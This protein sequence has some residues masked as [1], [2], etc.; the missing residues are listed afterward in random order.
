MSAPASAPPESSAADPPAA[1]PSTAGLRVVRRDGTVSGFD[2]SKIAVAMTKAFLAVEGGDAGASSR[3]HHLVT[4]LTAQVRDALARFPAAAVHVEQIQDQ[5][6]LALMRGEHH[7]AARSYVLYREERAKARDAAGPAAEHSTLHVT[8]PDGTRH[9]LDWDRLESVVGE[10]VAGIDAV[11]AEPVLAE[12]RRNLYDGITADEL[13]QAPVMAARTLVEL[14]P[15]Y[16]FVAAR[17]L[18]GRLRGEALSYLAG[19]PRRLDQAGMAE[20]YPDYVRDYLRRAIELGLADPELTR[21]DLDRLTAAIRPERDLDFGF[22]GL[23]TLYDRYFLHH[24]GTRFELP[25]AFFLR[26]AMGLAVRERDREARAI[27][28]YELL[29]RLDFM[30]STPTLFNA[31]TTRPQ[32]SSCFLTTVDDDLDSIFQAY[33]NN[34]LLAKY[35]GGL[36]NDWTPVRGLGAHI[37]GTNGESQG[38]VPFLKIASDTAVAVNQGGK[39]KGAACAYLETWHID[40]EEFLDLRK[41][42]GDD[43]RRT[44]DMNTA[45]WVPDEFLRRVEADAEWTLFSPDETPDLHD[46]YGVEFALRYRAYESAADRGEIRVVKR[47]RAVEL[48]R[49]ML[50]VLFETGHPWITFKDPCNLRSPQQHAG[51]VHSSNLCTEITL[52][53]G[54]AE[55]AVCNLSSVNLLT[56][57]TKDGLD[58]EKLRRTVTT[59]V[60]ML[61]NVID[62]NFYTIPEARRSNLRHR[63]IGLGLM[64]FQ[65]ALFEQGIPLASDAAVGFAD[66]SMEHLSYHAIAASSALAAERGRYASF[67]GSLWSKG[68]LPIDS[69]ALLEA[70]REGDGLDVDRTSTLDWD[71]LRERVRIVGM[72]NSNVMAIAPTATISNICGVGQSIEPQFRN[73]FVKSNM[74][75]DFTVINPHLVRSLKER[76]LWDEVMISDLK[77]FDGSLGEIDRV[78]TDLK[79][80][81]ATAFEIEPRWLVEAASRRQKWID[82]AQSLNLYLAAPSGRRLDELYRLAWRKGLKTTYYLRAQS[83]TH[84][85]K[86]TLKGTDGKLRG[87]PAAPS[88]ATAVPVPDPPLTDGAACRIDEPDCEACQ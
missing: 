56:H 16:S 87:V 26:V 31:G 10:A 43:R 3:L 38:V 77:Y 44:H 5:V 50:T 1:D 7:K 51:V 32:L 17:L 40:V 6:E 71:G 41:N 61:D 78:P 67:D 39:R 62:I 88:A 49:R 72:R 74:S 47:V 48:W 53:T 28:F 65:D 18:L 33:R 22:L 34:A 66:R 84:V 23:Q 21:F 79:A 68:L 11:S 46:L 20:A 19:S 82:Q 76:G 55:V 36:G 29:S 27:E 70:A 85:E 83:A 4:E 60:R 8:D 54:P 9:P 30:A 35:S 57:V 25:Q 64:G 80:L 42:T 15:D 13:A 59:A 81:Y 58:S 24:R 86:S 75:G 14:E 73:L 2:G 52:N 69:I 45:N 12:T 63:P 37:K